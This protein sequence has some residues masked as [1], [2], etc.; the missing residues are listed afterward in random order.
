MP[1]LIITILALSTDITLPFFKI[2]A[3]I[4]NRVKQGV[5]VMLMKVEAAGDRS[6]CYFKSYRRAAENE[7]G[8]EE[9][10]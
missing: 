1:Q 3:S 4:T 9:Q 5:Q 8:S 10:H 7:L 2:N 6:E